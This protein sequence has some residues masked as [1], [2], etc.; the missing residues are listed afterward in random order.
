MVLVLNLDRFES[1]KSVL[2]VNVLAVHLESYDKLQ[3]Y[4]RKCPIPFWMRIVSF[5]FLLRIAK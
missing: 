1:S 4:D 2:S 3:L 5:I